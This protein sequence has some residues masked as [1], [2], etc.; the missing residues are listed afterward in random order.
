MS[1]KNL[2]KP[3]NKYDKLKLWS[4]FKEIWVKLNMGNEYC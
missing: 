4:P 1:M 3:I 2:I